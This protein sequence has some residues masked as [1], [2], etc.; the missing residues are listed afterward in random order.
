MRFRTTPAVVRTDGE[1][2]RMN[3]RGYYSTSA[4]P[5]LLRKVPKGSLK[6]WKDPNGYLKRAYIVMG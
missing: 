6:T 4:P 3:P 5:E 2:D 1:L